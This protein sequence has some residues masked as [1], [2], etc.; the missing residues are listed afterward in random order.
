MDGRGTSVKRHA[1]PTHKLN[2]PVQALPN[3]AF[4]NWVVHNDAAKAGGIH[5]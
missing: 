5:K 1:G 2:T 4:N 3:D